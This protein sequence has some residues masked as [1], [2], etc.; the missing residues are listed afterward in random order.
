MRLVEFI[1]GTWAADK[2]S[3]GILE[4][5]MRWAINPAHVATVTESDDGWCEIAMADGTCQ[6]VKGD[7]QTVL[8]RLIDDGE[9]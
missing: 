9:E 4:N 7:W 1:A 5:E 8:A 6:L 3:R 2:L